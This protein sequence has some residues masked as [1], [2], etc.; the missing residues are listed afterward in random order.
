MLAT[1]RWS[2]ALTERS[3]R[4]ALDILGDD[5]TNRD[6]VE[7]TRQHVKATMRRWHGNTLSQKRAIYCSFFD[8]CM[9]EGIRE[10]NP[11]RQTPKVRARATPGYRLTDVEVHAMLAAA[12]G[13]Y[14]RRVLSLGFHVGLRSAELRGLQ[15]VHFQRAGWIWVSADIAKGSKERWVPVLPDIAGIADEIRAGVR[16][17]D[18]H[19]PLRLIALAHREHVANRERGAGGSVVDEGRG[20]GHG[21]SVS[22]RPDSQDSG[23]ATPVAVSLACTTVGRDVLLPVRSQFGGLGCRC[24]RH[25][26]DL[27]LAVGLDGRLNDRVIH[28]GAA[29]RREREPVEQTRDEVSP[30]GRELADEPHDA[31]GVDMRAL[32]RLPLGS[33]LQV[34]VATHRE[35]PHERAGREPMGDL[36]VSHH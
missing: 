9:E 2:S 27:A 24:V 26:P 29:L 6:P 8:W 16:E 12:D 32:E 7:I 14:E 36:D 34:P 25:R 11:A 3:Y 18:Q 22:A 15:G 10:T 1:G 35:K 17:R 33:Q 19:P 21:W 31:V 20:L 30:A 28:H 23:A 5:V 13:A 4:R